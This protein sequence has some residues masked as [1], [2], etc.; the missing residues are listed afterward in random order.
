MA[1]LLVYN[2]NVAGLWD[3]LNRFI[4]ELV[5]S[6]SSN[7]TEFADADVKR[8]K[9]YLNELTGYIDWI[10]S[11][12]A[13]D[14][15]ETHPKGR[16]LL[17]PP[18]VPAISNPMV[19]DALFLLQRLRGELVSSESARRAS[20][21]TG[22]DEARARAVIARTESFLEDYVAKFTPLD[23]PESSPKAPMTGPGIV[24]V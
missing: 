24:G 23:L 18:L 1:E 22:F 17:E 9:S 4:V 12:P 11:A 5:R 13:M 6:T 2:D 21:L 15:P 14:Y 19:N 10:V 3:R 8:L 7:I 20:G 16:T